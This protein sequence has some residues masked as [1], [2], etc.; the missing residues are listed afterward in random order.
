MAVVFKGESMKKL[1]IAGFM[2]LSVAGCIATP[3]V[4]PSTQDEIVEIRLPVGYIPNVQFA[5]LYVAME[6]GYFTAENINV[7][8]DYSFETD[9]V[10]L[11]G[12]G[13][14][15]FAIASGEQVLLARA[16]EIPIVY[17]MAWY[18][19][20]PVA[21]ASK[22]GN[23]MLQPD[24]LKGK[25]IGI[26]ILSG[27][28]Y[29]GL[30]AI[31]DAGGLSENDVMLKTIGFNQVEM[32]ATDRVD[33]VVVYIANEPVVLKSQGYPTDLIRV[34]DYLTLVSNGLITNENTLTDNP[35][36]VKRMVRAILNGI[37]DAIADPEGAYRISE[38]Y[39]ETLAQ[40]DEIVQKQVLD[41]SIE[42]WKGPRLGFSDPIAWSNM[43]TVLKSMGL[44]KK[45]IDAIQA[46]TNDFLP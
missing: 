11:L 26:P 16:Q 10:A 9:A 44:L 24:D 2:V 17:V 21:V 28:S 23:G 22:A 43:L 37:S 19:N 30:R 34:D 7:T 46:F 4:K 13:E 25:T 39:V 31:L 15:Q 36:L 32:L 8:L 29:I 18:Q 3:S 1:I 33:A 6:K 42:L 14:L 45:E 35:D 38:K 12:A 20:Y 5:P 27:A 41:Q 40:A